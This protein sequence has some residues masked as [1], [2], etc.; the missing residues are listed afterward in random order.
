MPCRQLGSLQ[1][2]R[3]ESCIKRG[4]ENF[5][6][7]TVPILQAGSWMLGLLAARADRMS[8]AFG[9]ANGTV[10][11]AG[12]AVPNTTEGAAVGTTANLTSDAGGAGPSPATR[13]WVLTGAGSTPDTIFVTNANWQILGSISGAGGLMLNGWGR[14]DGGPATGSSVIGTQNELR[15]GGTNTYG[16][17]TTINFGTLVAQNGSAIPN[18][19]RVSFSTQSVW[20]GPDAGH[21]T[22]LDTAVLRV[23][24]SETVG[25]LAGGNA[26]RGSVNINGA[27]VTLTTGA[28]GTTSTFS[29]S[30]IGTGG[31]TKTGAGVFTMDGAKSYTGD[32]K[33]LGGT[34]STNSASLADAADVYLMTGA[35]FNL[36]FAGTDTIRSLFFDSTAQAIG[37][38][39]ALGSA[40]RIRARCF[41]VPAC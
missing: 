13:S 23:D 28:D 9:A 24:A 27:A 20:G 30:V 31:L 25:S 5:V 26:T 11:V 3:P 10:T 39:G 14:M 17:A 38:W 34:L 33:V 6:R 37:T 12:G 8:A 7:S 18:G 35:L 32:T 2:Q 15:L 29:G 21:Q 19:S 1:A 4:T 22:T 36:N 16:G 40:L 41:R